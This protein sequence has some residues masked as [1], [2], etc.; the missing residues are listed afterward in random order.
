MPQF[1]ASTSFG[2]SS[3]LA[4]EIRGLGVKVHNIDSLGCSFSGNWKDAFKVNLYSRLATRVS[5]TVL[6]FSAYNTDEI[7]DNLKKHDFT[8]YMGVSQTF[9]VTGS[10]RDCAIRDQRATVLKF[11]DL[12]A[13]QFR[14]KYDRRPNVEKMMPDMRF[15]IHG[16]KNQF[17]ASVDTSGVPLTRR[18][19]RKEAGEAPLKEHLA[20]GVLS[21][22]GWDYQTPIIDPACGSGTLLIEAALKAARVQPGTFRK[23][24]AFQKFSHLESTGWDDVVN[25]ALEAEDPEPRKLFFGFDKDR[26]VLLRA[27]ENAKRAGVEDWIEFQRGRMEDFEK[28]EDL[29]EPGFIITNPPYGIRMGDEFFLEELY[30]N[31]GFHLKTNFKGWHLWLLSGKP[32]LTRH[33]GLKSDRRY[34]VK[35][36]PIE[37]RLLSYKIR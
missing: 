4:D 31:F 21:L 29:H 27:M 37:C 3:T 5:L 34:P 1:Y 9:M 6:E 36:G 12:I 32:E 19:Y 14:D 28:P 23:G 26:K 10:V 22:S 15:S 35:N 24:F 2:L 25:E 11:K 18:G 30:K 33:L 20:A 8:R 16:Y 7:Y 17:H 13:D